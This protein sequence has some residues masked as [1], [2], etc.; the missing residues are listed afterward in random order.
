MSWLL[1][2]KPQRVFIL[3]VMFVLCAWSAWDVYIDYQQVLQQEYRLQEVRAR[4]HE[5]RVSGDSPSADLM[6]GR[7]PISA[8]RCQWSMKL[9]RRM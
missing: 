3:F 8:R 2:R 7:T 1:S 6:L 5:A 4:H 9:A